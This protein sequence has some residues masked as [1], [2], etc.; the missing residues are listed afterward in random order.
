MGYASAAIAF[1]FS[2]TGAIQ[3]GAKTI[4]YLESSFWSFLSDFQKKDK[5]INMLEDEEKG[6]KF[7]GYMEGYALDTAVLVGV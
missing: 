7:K 1:F 4:Y 2:V 5:Y 6:K 3:A